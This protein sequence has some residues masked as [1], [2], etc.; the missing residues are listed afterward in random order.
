MTMI[1]ML[2]CGA[3]KSDAEITGC[4]DD[5][6]ERQVMDRVVGASGRC[7]LVADSRIGGFRLIVAPAGM[8]FG[9]RWV[10]ARYAPAL[11]F[12]IDRPSSGYHGEIVSGSGPERSDIDCRV[13]PGAAVPP[14]M[15][16]GMHGAAGQFGK[17]WDEVDLIEKTI[18]KRYLIL[19]TRKRRAIFPGWCRLLLHV[20]PAND[21]WDGFSNGVWLAEI[22]M[23]CFG[24]GKAGDWGV[25]DGSGASASRQ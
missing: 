1:G 21:L 7:Y 20:K 14:D 16:R 15:D 8:P 9:D 6:T 23:E 24:E 2:A 19:R 17:Q 22:E 4:A 11:N 12:W 10:P 5:R 3:R 13:A 25:K 18:G